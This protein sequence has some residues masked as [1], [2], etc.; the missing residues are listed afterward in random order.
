[1]KRIA[2]CA[3]A[4]CCL[5]PCLI[6]PHGAF[7]QTPTADNSDPGQALVDDKGNIFMEEVDVPKKKPI[8]KVPIDL[9]RVGVSV[10]PHGNIVP[11]KDGANDPWAG[12][13][14]KPFYNNI[15]QTTELPYAGAF[16]PY[17]PGLNK[18]WNPNY[19]QNVM[20][21]GSPYGSP[22]GNPYGYGGP[23]Y[24]S[25]YG[26]PYNFANNPFGFGG[27]PYGYG[28]NPYGI[29]SSPYGL[30]GLPVGNPYYNP[31]GYNSYGYN[32]YGYNPY[33]NYGGQPVASL[34]L[35]NFQATLSTNPFLRPNTT[36]SQTSMW[37]AFNLAF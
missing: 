30:A 1:M 37:K 29:N 22:Y 23:N 26:N 5:L 32:P 27:N 10:D 35:G 13:G 3:L 36:F 15:E 18:T 11:L 19:G 14:V 8:T 33:G 6:S 17:Y 34:R 16:A 4:L 12:S 20:P 28:I 21:Y 9:S 31:Y 24:G 25:P 7:G 2:H